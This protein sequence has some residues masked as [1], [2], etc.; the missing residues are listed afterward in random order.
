MNFNQMMQD[1]L[2]VSASAVDQIVQI[3]IENLYDDYQEK[4]IQYERQKRDE[5]RHL[6]Q[7]SR[8]M[9]LKMSTDAERDLDDLRGRL[10][11]EK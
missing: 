3:E 5:L 8:N 1:P 9:K 6:E 7:E 10:E 11:M 2:E 4:N